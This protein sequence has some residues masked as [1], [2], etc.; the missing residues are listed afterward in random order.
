MTPP[1]LAV[2]DARSIYREE[3]PNGIVVLAYQNPAVQSVTL[4]GSLSAGALYERQPHQGVAPLMAESLMHGTYTRDFDAI[5]SLLEDNAAD[6]GY[7]SGLMRLG[8]SGK[9]LAGDL[10]LLLE[11]LSDTLRHPAFPEDRLAIL[12]EQRITSLRYYEQDAGYRA[13]RAFRALVFPPGTPGSESIYGTVESIAAMTRDDLADFHQRVVGPRGMTI[14]IVGSEAPES[15]A[16]RVRQYLGD[17]QAPH[18]PAARHMPALP[19]PAQ[20]QR[21]ETP[22]PGKTQAEIVL[23]TLGPS[24]YAPDYYAALLANA[25]L[26]EFGMMGRVGHNIREK[27]GLAYH[28]SSA[29]E[30]VEYNGPWSIS[31]GV[32]P[33]NVPLAIEKAL[34]EVRALTREG[35]SAQELDDVQSYYVGRMPLRLESSSG[36]ANTI[37]MM[38]RYQLGLDYLVYYPELIRG[39]TQQDVLRAAQHYL[40]P[41][42]VIVSIAGSLT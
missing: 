2:P 35:V 6:F 13:N 28:A 38:E 15:A 39:V 42:A 41:D 30:A 11:V 33:H 19:S 27:S 14:A 3:L 17:W 4:V 1:P 37:E 36:I 34:D 5:A 12:Q 29:L 20:P 32:A 25:V 10:P 18:Q 23:G 40:N 16:D 26:G 21:V 24:R 7:G 8:F 31:A 9:A 22:I